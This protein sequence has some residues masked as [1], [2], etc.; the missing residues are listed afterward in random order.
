MPSVP[1]DA[2]DAIELAELPGLLSDWPESDRD[3]LTAPL[4]RFTG[5]PAYGPDSL[6]AT[7]PGSGFSSAS[8]AAT[9]SGHPG[10]GRCPVGQDNYRSYKS[11]FVVSVRVQRHYRDQR[12]AGISRP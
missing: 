11:A 4:A 3:C 12:P 8:P 1:V 5:S 10:G 7:S 9:M 6:Q 2:G